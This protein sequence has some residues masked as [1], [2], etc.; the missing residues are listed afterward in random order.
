MSKDCILQYGLYKKA[1]LD[2]DLLYFKTSYSLTFV[3]GND[4]SISCRA[5]KMEFSPSYGGR[6]S[7]K[8]IVEVLLGEETHRKKD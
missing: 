2:L 6:Q 3:T 8:I 4:K 1:R 5:H 7:R